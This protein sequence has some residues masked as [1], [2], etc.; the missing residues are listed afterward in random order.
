MMIAGTLECWI[1]RYREVM[2]ALG[3]PCTAKFA[4]YEA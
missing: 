4:R 1:T 2:T 3:G